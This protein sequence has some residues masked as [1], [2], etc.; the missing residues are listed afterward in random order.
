[1]WLDSNMKWRTILVSEAQGDLPHWS[2]SSM[3]IWRGRQCHS[4]LQL[5]IYAAF[6]S[7]LPSS[8]SNYVCVLFLLLCE[9]SLEEELN[10]MCGGMLVMPDL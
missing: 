4:P 7:P 8:P 10:C 2:A 3:T 1:M 6:P 5:F 9:L